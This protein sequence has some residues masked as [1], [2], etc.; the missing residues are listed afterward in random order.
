MLPALIWVQAALATCG[1]DV[2]QSGTTFTVMPTGTDDT[3]NIQCAFDEAVAAGP[4]ATVELIKG[5]YYTA[6]IV[7]RDF[8]GSF[9]GA[10]MKKTVVQNLPNLD[11][12]VTDFLGTEPCRIDECDDDAEDGPGT[13]PTIFSFIGGDFTVSQ[14]TIRAVGEEPTAGWSFFGLNY[15]E[16]SS[17]IVVLGPEARISVN[18]VQVEGEETEGV[19]GYNLINGIF[20]E[21]NFGG[22]CDPQKGA[23]T[24]TN[25]TFLKVYD[26]VPVAV[27]ENYRAF[28]SHNTFENVGASV[29]G[30]Y[31]PDTDIEFSHNKVD[32]I[33][34]FLLYDC[35]LFECG[36]YQEPL[37]A[38]GL[39]DSTLL[40]TNNKFS[41][42]DG[43]VLDISF[44]G[45]VK[46][47]LRGNNVSTLEGRGIYLGP[48][49]NNC[50]VIGSGRK[51]NIVDLGTDNEVRGKRD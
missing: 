2:V 29:E 18:R 27:T 38:I 8:V 11:V 39:K 25:S 3:A 15:T 41:G 47:L 36:E 1:P 31:L 24:V 12:T 23:F 35:P 46:C 49:T 48:N 10:G 14:M 45:D 20:P 40:I 34:G 50:V 32:G 4:G 6:Q 44:A 30:C 7:V 22:N 37:P 26:A 5:T 19:F 33:A 51:D 28:I 9:M 21:G 42:G 16:L 17:A 13:W 43:V